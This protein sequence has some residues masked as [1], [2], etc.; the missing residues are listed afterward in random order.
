MR[1]IVIG[2]SPFIDISVAIGPFHTVDA[3]LAAS[4]GLTYRGYGTEICHLQKLS[5]IP[6][7]TGATD[8]D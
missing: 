4:S 3:A 1:Y 8:K 7:L 2:T 5:D 6:T